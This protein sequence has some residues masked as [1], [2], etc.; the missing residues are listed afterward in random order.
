MSMLRFLLPAFLVAACGGPPR[1]VPAT[2]EAAMG[3]VDGCRAAF[4]RP[5]FRVVHSL[6]AT[7]PGDLPGAFLG[8]T[9]TGDGGRT[10]RS[11]L[12]SLE[13][14]VLVDV[15]SAGDGISVHRVLPPLDGEGFAQGMAAD[16][17]LLLFPPGEVPAAVGTDDEGRA[18]CRW[19]REGGGSTDVAVSGAEGWT[20]RSWDADGK[21]L[22]EVRATGPFR[23]GFARRME[24]TAPGARGYSLVLEL[25]EVEASG[26][27][28]AETPVPFD[29]GARRP[30]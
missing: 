25:V 8:V 18:V 1:L 12:L 28:G 20:L 30:L 10:F 19:V 5:D 4:P 9:A 16:I 23:E 17:R 2:P 7:L 26:E 13:G 11:E 22:R 15:E 24:L 3:M 21:L 29:S 14:M 6:T 27:V